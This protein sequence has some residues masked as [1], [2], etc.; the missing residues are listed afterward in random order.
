L[1]FPEVFAFGPVFVPAVDDF[2]FTAVFAKPDDLLPALFLAADD[3]VA[4]EPVTVPLVLLFV[5]EDFDLPPGDFD[6]P[7]FDPVD[8]ELDDFVA[9]AFFVVGIF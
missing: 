5:D 9:E 8:R 6:A 2:D 3:L 4:F 1:C 7:D